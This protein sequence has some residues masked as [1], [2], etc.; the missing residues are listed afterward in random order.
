VLFTGLSLRLEGGECVELR[1]PN[2]SGK[3]TLIRTLAG[4]LP[5][6]GQVLAR[7]KMAYLGHTNGLA[8]PLSPLE[9]LRWYLGIV[10]QAADDRPIHTA[11]SRL[12]IAGLIRQPVERLSAGQQRR[13]A[14]ARLLIGSAPVWLLD[15]PYTALD[16][17]GITC[18]DG[19]LREHV[20]SGGCA[21]VASHSPVAVA[22]RVI[23]LTGERMPA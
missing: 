2:G 20:A 1:G 3:T 15:E 17:S 13:V 21:L 14:L 23:E 5:M 8:G 9:N 7:S 11:L 4:L 18:V 10:G 6:Q 19:L 16:A 12:Q 22:T